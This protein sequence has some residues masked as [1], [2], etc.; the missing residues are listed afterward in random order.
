[1][2]ENDEKDL[3][4]ESQ[5][6][7]DD[8]QNEAAKAIQ[9]KVRG[10]AVREKQKFEIIQL[11][12]EKD[13]SGME[14]K[15]LEAMQLKELKA[16]ATN[17][18]VSAAKIKKTKKTAESLVPDEAATMVQSAWRGKTAKKEANIRKKM[19]KKQ[20]ARRDKLKDE[21]ELKALNDVSKFFKPGQGAYVRS[22]PDRPCTDCFC[23]LAFVSYWFGMCYLIWFAVTY[24]EI[25]R[26]VR[27]R[28]MN[29][30]TCGLLNGGNDGIDLRAFP[31]LYLPNPADETQQICVAGCP[32]NTPGKCM[33][34]VFKDSRDEL[35]VDSSGTPFEYHVNLKKAVWNGRHELS[36]IVP[37]ELTSWQRKQ[38]AADAFGVPPETVLPLQVP[39]MMSETECIAVGDCNEESGAN[40]G[41]YVES[42]E[43]VR[44][45]RCINQTR[46]LEDGYTQQVA[47]RSGANTWGTGEQIAC[48]GTSDLPTGNRFVPFEWSPYVWEYDES[49]DDSL[50]ICIPPDGCDPNKHPGCDGDNYP[51]TTFLEASA[52]GFLS[53][54]GPCWLPVLPSQ[55]YLFRCVPTLLLETAESS[56]TGSTGSAEGQVSVQYMKDLQ[57]YWRVIPFGVFMAILVAFAW[58]IFLGKFAYYIIV[59]TC[60]L[61]PVVSLAI[62]VACFY[63]LGAIP[64][65]SCVAASATATGAVM[66]A[67]ASAD[68]SFNPQVI[69]YTGIA[70]QNCLDAA[71]NDGCT[72]EPGLFVDIPPEV[73]AAMDEANTTEQYTTIVAWSTLIGAFVLALIFVIFWDRVMISIGVIEEASDAFLDI[74]FAIFLPL[75]VLV[76]SLPVSLYCCF[77]C[78]L[79]LSLRRIAE[80]GAVLWCLPKDDNIPLADLEQ[81]EC[82]F[83]T[84]LQAMFFAQ[85]FGWL[86]T[87]QWF[88]STQYTT[89]A[90]AVS[91]WYFT[92]EDPKTHAKRVSAVLL[93]HSAVRTVR[94]HSGTMA[95]GSFIISVVICVKFA[96]VY[97]INQ[98]Q[99]QSPE[100]KLIKVLGNVLKACVACVERFVRFVGHLAY[101]E[102]AIYGNNF[103]HALFK[104]VKALAT[105]AVR[106]SFVA[107]FSQLVLTLGKVAV[108][109]V[110]LCISNLLLDY[111]KSPTSSVDC[112]TIGETEDLCTADGR[113]KW[114]PDVQTCQLVDS[115]ANDLPNQSAP[116]FPMALVFFFSA[117]VSLNIMGVYETAI[118]TI[119]VSFLEDESEND[120]NGQVTF[121][122]GPLKQFMKSTKS[123]ADATQAYAE[124]VRKAKTDKIRADAEVTA[125]MRDSD[126]TPGG[127]NKDLKR[128]RKEEREG[129]K[130]ARKDKVKSESKEE[131]KARKK[132]EKAEFNSASKGI[133]GHE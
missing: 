113:C 58:I 76:A 37:T 12:V 87:V 3:E 52:N 21:A 56:V 43:C 57:D 15:D 90:G 19:K 86:W 108:V 17:L 1:M 16:V 36:L 60:I 18:G 99:A 10:N 41:M 59:G 96:L 31:Q 71:G 107:L 4:A 29:G 131:K 102:T 103:C 25:D 126:L 101:I 42:T 93:S 124:A 68:L 105:N 30:H 125:K 121:A 69:D 53:Q 109:V 79:L 22:G 97:M 78:F 117:T 45:G 100:N 114:D 67:C 72:Y 133:N 95:F 34:A 2:G 23:C 94:H 88:L 26:L 70:E 14:I 47:H 28:D 111:F 77:A 112:A 64:T 66:E 51:P 6:D 39:W 13:T 38:T 120:G 116:V 85:L 81:D 54:D 35:S 63:K 104:A 127:G 123:I 74:P 24:G 50:F 82:I 84:I 83:P 110:S 11:I 9:A 48:E 62:S 40:A 73:Q 106:F 46:F 32:G 91:K 115:T 5:E 8:K 119:M 7:V 128:K 65:R 118:D 27:P 55:E 80:D 129:K 49:D 130:K 98:V 61:S 132:R 20:Q 44:R 75:I 89:I 122:D 33:G 92:P